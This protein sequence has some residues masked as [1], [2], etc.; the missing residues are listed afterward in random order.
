MSVFSC[1]CAANCLFGYLLN[2]RRIG[3]ENSV[4]LFPR[5]G[6]IDDIPTTFFRRPS[7][8]SAHNFHGHMGATGQVARQCSMAEPRVDGVDNDKGFSASGSVG[9]FSD[10]EELEEFGD[11]IA[12]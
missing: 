10:C 5:Y 2:N 8:R 1:S 3:D 6:S 4:G 11:E 7:Q 12:G 9:D